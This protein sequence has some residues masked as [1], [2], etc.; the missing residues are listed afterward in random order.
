M[1]IKN[2][3]I[4]CFRNF[5]K[6]HIELSDGINVFYGNNAQ[7]KTN[8]IEAVFIAAMGKSFRFCPDRD[9]IFFG[10][11]RANINVEYF[12][13]N[14]LNSNTVILNK[15]ERK[16]M[17][18]NGC[19]IKK[20]M[21]FIGKLNVI[22]FTPQELEIIKEGPYFRRRFIDVCAGQLRSRYLFALSNYTK[23]V[24]QKNKLLK[25]GD[26]S[27]ISVWNERL[28]EYGSIVLWYRIS[29]FKKIKEMI[30]PVYAEITEYK[31]EITGAYIKSFKFDD[32]L[33]V[34]EIKEVF[35]KALESK[36]QEEKEAGA[37]LIGPHRDDMIFY[38]NGKNAKN[39]GSQGQQRSIVLALKL[40]QSDLFYEETGE[41]PVLLLDDIASELDIVR[42]RYL[43]DKIKD[44]QVI[45]TCTD[46][47]KIENSQYAAYFNVKNGSII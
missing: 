27:T 7:G 43:F 22:L 28:A 26:S 21:D 37:S 23:V 38:I 12:S 25:E 41:Y 44:K 2:I 34:K 33:S 16:I 31:E 36:E 5:K 19:N 13:N 40:V 18:V 35:L 46:A 4:S 45:I 14:M 29:L 11:Q 17:K 15:S 32:D 47:E 3:E 9:I 39:F 30:K 20:R 6:Q 8:L 10:E 24:E 42:R 1:I